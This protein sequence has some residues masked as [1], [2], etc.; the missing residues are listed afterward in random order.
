M[1]RDE[2]RRRFA[3]SPVAT[4]ATATP[5]GVPHAVPIVFAVG[6]GDEGDTI[7][8]GVD[9]KPK[10]HHRLRRL[11]N[12]RANPRAAV[13]VDHYDDDWSALW[14]VR[15]EGTA[16]EV[17]PDGPEGRRALGLLRRRFPGYEL[18]GALL[19]IDVT[20]WS[21]WSAAP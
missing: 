2:A 12:L 20:R 10:R 14:W 21:G 18:R 9:A 16:R 3:A 4:L 6:F 11:A 17:D 7:Y 1:N 15:A 5:D 19:G 8:H 13:L